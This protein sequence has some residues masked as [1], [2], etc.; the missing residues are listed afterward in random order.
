MAFNLRLHFRYKNSY[1][2][3]PLL[4]LSRTVKIHLW[5]VK[6]ERLLPGT[7][8]DTTNKRQCHNKLDS[9]Y[10]HFTWTKIPC[11]TYLAYKTGI[12]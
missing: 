6:I 11:T 8:Y 2:T 4:Q 1:R 10:T 9:F 3:K 12:S 7:M 5:F